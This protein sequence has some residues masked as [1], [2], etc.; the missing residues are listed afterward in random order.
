MLE[1]ERE[2]KYRTQNGETPSYKA[3]HEVHITRDL[4]SKMNEEIA[5]FVEQHIAEFKGHTEEKH[6]IPVMLFERNQDAHAF[7]NELSTK[8]KIRKEHITVKAQKYTR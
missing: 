8:L 6:G 2:H 4:G 1:G 5:A 3:Y 7:S